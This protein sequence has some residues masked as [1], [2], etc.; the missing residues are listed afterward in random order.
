MLA[1]RTVASPLVRAVL[2]CPVPG[3]MRR[4]RA[5]AAGALE[6]EGV[7]QM[8]A[9]RTLFE[10]VWQDHVVREAPGEPALV[11]IDL[12][13]VHEVTSPQ[14]FESLRLNGRPVRR[15][16]LTIAT[17]DHNVATTDRS[18]PIEDPISKQQLDAL[19]RNC[20]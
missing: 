10:K 8:A 1:R 14:P 13:L 4:V 15:P 19:D 3:P 18:L 12:H 17:A 20:A 6:S 7:R 5:R 11:Y 2:A 16:D 9:P